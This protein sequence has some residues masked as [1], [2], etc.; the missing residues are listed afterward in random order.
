M[1]KAQPAPSVRETKTAGR[2]PFERLRYARKILFPREQ[3]ETKVK[4]F[5]DIVFGPCTLGRTWG[6]RPA[7]L[8]R[9]IDG[10]SRFLPKL[11]LDKLEIQVAPPPDFL[12]NLVALA[13]FMRL[14]SLKGARAASS[15]AARQGNPG[16]GL[17]F[18]VW[19]VTPLLLAS[20]RASKACKSDS[21]PHAALRRRMEGSTHHRAFPF[22]KS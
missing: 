15:S 20:K 14:S 8:P 16:S 21:L 13:N 2:S 1:S 11:N 9:L 7:P 3:S 18:G 22:K 12:W 10:S 19:V 5:E 17:D 6:T 4:A